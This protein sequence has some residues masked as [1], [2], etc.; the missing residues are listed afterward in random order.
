[1]IQYPQC[2]CV[3]VS[4]FVGCLKVSSYSNAQAWEQGMVGRHSNVHLLQAGI[5]FHTAFQLSLLAL[6]CFAVRPG[7]CLSVHNPAQQLSLLIEVRKMALC[8]EPHQALLAHLA[9]SPRSCLS[10]HKPCAATLA[11]VMTLTDATGL[12]K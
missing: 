3:L 2:L 12:I 11:V 1:M 5:L 6:Q 10:V 9:A 8:R 7:G 4:T